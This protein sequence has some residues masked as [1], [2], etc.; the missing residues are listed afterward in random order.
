MA[1]HYE[2]GARLRNRRLSLGV[3]QA[4][5]AKA[6]GIS[7]SYLNLIEHNRRAIGVRL[8]ADL[9]AQLGVDADQMAEG[10]ATHVL[11]PMMAASASFPEA[12]A[13]PEQAEQLIAQSPGWAGLIAAQHA[14][15]AKLEQRLEALRNR[16]AHDTQ[17]ATSVHEVISTA[18]AIRSTA[19]ILTET[20][21]LDAEWQARFHRNIDGEAERLAAS[22][23]S[24]L[25]LLDQ[26]AEG[27][28]GASVLDLAEAALER[29]GYILSP[30]DSFE[31]VTSDAVR[32]VLDGWAAQMRADA[33]SV[34]EQAFAA[35]A[36]ACAYDPARLAAKIDAPLDRVL[37]RLA[38]LPDTGHPP[39][40]VVVCDAAGVVT[41]QKPVRNFR[42]PRS[43]TACPLWP[44]FRALNQVGS[45]VYDVVQLTGAA[46]TP[47]ECIAIAGPAGPVRFDAPPRIV[48]TM[49]VRPVPEVPEATRL[50][51]GCRLCPITKC[52]SRRLPS[53]V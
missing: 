19:S 5:L 7:A 21:D 24:L 31:E 2:V 4:S 53:L 9:C 6:V 15:I 22:S 48:S 30:D 40:G 14:Q 20:P 28:D 41:Y 35:A 36:R 33:V 39:M 34:S 42:L 16:M 11:G 27:P 12:Q 23:Q 47:F 8:L 25:S 49:L 26:E 38:T 17:I 32:A 37:R 51:P 52:E 50:G 10:P 44:L 29:R 3:K 1:Q 18:T 46:Q 13:E 45:P 43:G